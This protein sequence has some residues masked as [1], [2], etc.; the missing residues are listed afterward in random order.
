VTDESRGG[1]GSTY[2]DRPMIKE[3]VWIWAVPV[4]FYAGGA[5]GAAAAFGA[6]AQTF[7]RRGFSELIKKCR[8]IAAAGTATGSALLI[9]D[10]GRPERFMNMLR[11]FRP[12]SVLSIGSWTL[13]AGGTLSGMS[14]L[15]SERLPVLGDAAGYASGLVGL[16]L[17]GYTA[18]LLSDTAVPLWQET[19]RSLPPLFVASAVASAAALLESSYMSAQEERAVERM[20]LLGKIGELASMV[21]VEREA[22]RVAQVAGPLKQEPGGSLWR[23]A[24]TLI[25]ASLA[26]SL[27]PRGGRKKRALSGVLSTAGSLALRFAMFHAGKASAR[28]PR[29]TV[30]QQRSG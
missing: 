21:F 8:W 14:A 23:L 30:A 4:Y 24:R 5:A 17:S 7:D 20:S 29:A 13:A 10:L 15:L 16:P 18:V 3:P 11:V 22:R 2:Y 28:D 1:A 12:T 27:L 6:V 19:R 25:V 26:I 9:Y